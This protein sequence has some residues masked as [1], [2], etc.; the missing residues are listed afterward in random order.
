MRHMSPALLLTG[1]LTF[2]GCGDA[3]KP[4]ATI[5][6]YALFY[7]KNDRSSG[8]IYYG[9]VRFVNRDPAN[10]FSSPFGSVGP[11]EIMCG[12]FGLESITPG[13]PQNMIQI[14]GIVYRGDS[15]TNPIVDSLKSPVV[16]PFG[17]G[18]NTPETPHRFRLW[19]KADGT[20][21][22][23]FG[24]YDETAKWAAPPG[25]PCPTRF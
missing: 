9:Y 10:F 8:P 1:L 4:S 12:G 23:D 20:T 2:V 6:P 16:D 15:V 3:T 18:A 24:R 11:G 14:V 17:L 19:L 7:V 22:F 5:D 21:A 25:W 13:D